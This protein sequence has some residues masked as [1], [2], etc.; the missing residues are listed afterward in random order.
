MLIKDHSASL[1]LFDSLLTS[2]LLPLGLFLLWNGLLSWDLGGDFWKV[3]LVVQKA[4]GEKYN[5]SELCLLG[6]E[7]EHL[8]EEELDVVP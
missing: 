3:S 2:E 1:L 7:L 4:I 6:R 8:V 5:G